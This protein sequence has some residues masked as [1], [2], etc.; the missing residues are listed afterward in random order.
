VHNPK[1]DTPLDED[2]H[3]HSLQSPHSVRGDDSAACRH[4]RLTT[5]TTATATTATATTATATTPHVQLHTHTHV[6]EEARPVATQTEPPTFSSY[7]SAVLGGDPH[8][9]SQTCDSQQ[10][11]TVASRETGLELQSTAPYL[12]NEPCIAILS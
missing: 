5:A 3:S 1:A 6:C 10:T 9:H 12:H 11:T 8:T 2:G 4:R 7:W